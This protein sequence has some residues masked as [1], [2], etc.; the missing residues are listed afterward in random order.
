MHTIFHIRI[1]ILLK[2][3]FTVFGK[4]GGQSNEPDCVNP[5]LPFAN[6]QAANQSMLY[7]LNDC[8][9]KYWKADS[10]YKGMNGFR[11]MFGDD[12][13]MYNKSTVM[14]MDNQTMKGFRQ[15]RAK[16]VVGQT[17]GVI[18]VPPYDIV[19][20]GWSPYEVFYKF[21]T[22]GTFRAAGSVMQESTIVA[23]RMYFNDSSGIVK[24]SWN[25]STSSVIGRMMGGVFETTRAISDILGYLE[26][27]GSE[28]GGKYIEN[29]IQFI[30][31]VVFCVVT[32]FVAGCVYVFLKYA[33]ALCGAKRSPLKEFVL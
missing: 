5:T 4:Q 9:Y 18:D 29:P 25:N 30:F 28:Y 8:L 2:C 20:L 26:D 33:C 15:W 16:T 13:Y 21:T 1:L 32:I 23:R 17:L 22:K 27:D 12:G 31:T 14:K 10:A 3:I 24:C 11:Q 7:F 6:E 19:L